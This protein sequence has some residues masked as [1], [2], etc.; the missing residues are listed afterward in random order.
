MNSGETGITCVV[1][2]CEEET[3]LTI[4]NPKIKILATFY[5]K[6]RLLGGKESPED[7]FVE[8]YE[9]TEFTGNLKAERSSLTPSW[10]EDSKMAYLPMHEGDMKL[11]ELMKQ[12]GIYEVL[13]QYDKE[14]LIKF[15]TKKISWIALINLS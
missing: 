10:V 6:G 7:W 5:N 1:R 14:K 13:I 4:V 2:E 9:A 11:G 8:F 3:G 12:E 15:E